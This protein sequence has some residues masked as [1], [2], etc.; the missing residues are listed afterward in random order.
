[1]FRR[2]SPRPVLAAVLALLVAVPAP[3]FAVS[4]VS[5][6][7]VATTTTLFAENFQGS[8][9]VDHLAVNS[10]SRRYVS[11]RSG[12]GPDGS[13]CLQVA[14]APSSQ[15]SP[16]IVGSPRLSQ[17]TKDATVRYR[18][19]FRSDFQFVKGGKLPGLGAMESTTGCQAPE[20]DAWS[21]RV[22]WR[23][24]GVPELYVYDQDPS[25]R[26]GESYPASNA[27]FTPGKW[28][29]VAMYVRVNDSGRSNGYASLHVDGR[30]VAE[31]RNLRLC[32]DC[33]TNAQVNRFLFHTFYGGSS[34][35]WAPSTT[36]YA[37]FD[38]IRVV[39]GNATG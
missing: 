16:R 28:H 34:S 1:M 22:M 30:K 3:A 7:A 9:G 11:V 10:S 17:R 6:P 38:N 18:V 12:C 31:A 35:D 37:S 5:R 14:Y 27:R 26:C 32:T 13:R 25:N 33:T 2:L 24:N 23:A 39:K 8:A 4:S 19:K 20:R 36:T 29:D 15:G 21:S